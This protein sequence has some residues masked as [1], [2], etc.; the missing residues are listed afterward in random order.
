MLTFTTEETKTLQEVKEN[1]L[2]VP[3]VAELLGDNPSPKRIRL[4]EVKRNYMF[5]T[6]FR[7][8]NKTLK[9]NGL[10]DFNVVVQVLGGEEELAEGDI[11]LATRHRDSVNRLYLDQTEF[12]FKAS[13]APTLKELKEAFLAWKG[14]EVPE[15]ELR[16]F[17]YYLHDLEWVEWSDKLYQKWMDMR[18]KN[19]KMKLEQ[20]AKQK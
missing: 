12:I 4:R 10:E 7:N 15:D 11:V 16:L 5:G 3:L 9:G 1:L 6:I 13:K 8:H 19:S 17:K 14:L 2:T 18:E 20:K